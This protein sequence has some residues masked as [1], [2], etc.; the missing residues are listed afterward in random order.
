V[1]MASRK[2]GRP[3]APADALARLYD[4]DL[5]GET[6][7]LD[8]YVALAARTRGPVLELMAGSG[9]L[10]VPLAAMGR[11]VVAVD[12]EPAMLA[13][14]RVAA[15]A[16]GRGA[17]KRLELVLADA[18]GYR[19]PRRGR[20]GLA[21]VALGSLL[22]LPDRAAQRRV[23][24]ALADHLA[25]GGVAALDVPLLD[26]EDLARYD[27]RLTLDWV[28]SLPDGTVVT[29]SSSA[30]HDAA[31]RSVSLVTIFEEGIPGGPVTRHVRTDRLSLL[32]GLDLVEMA[33]AAGLRVEV[34][35]GDD[36]LT[37]L[38]AGADRAIVVAVRQSSSPATHAGD[39][40]G[41]W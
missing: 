8:L 27:G 2:A 26:A 18:D 17:A 3:E 41:A 28:R 29:K 33:E 23:V 31:T 34:L 7:D 39:G 6:S 21:F 12:L 35:A 4:L 25:P 5:A 16:A 10:A 11:K 37:P 32:D 15:S 19:H 22:L 13:R 1:T 24:V 20:F 38:A 14:G 40:A 30:R 9:R 36:G